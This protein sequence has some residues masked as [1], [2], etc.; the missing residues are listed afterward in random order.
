MSLE[1]SLP[2]NPLDS[3]K[4]LFNILEKSSI[5]ARVQDAG[6]PFSVVGSFVGIIFIMQSNYLSI[7]SSSVPFGW[8]IEATNIQSDCQKVCINSH[9]F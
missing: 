4:S 9:H 2:F 6:I 1:G 7:C 3:F 8:Q 5:D